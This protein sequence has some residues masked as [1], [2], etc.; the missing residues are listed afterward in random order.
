MVPVHPDDQPLLGIQWR[1]VTFVDRALPFGLRSAPKIFNSVADFPVWVLHC[2]GVSPLIHYLDDFLLFSPTQSM[3][4]AIARSR[5]ETVFSHIGAL[6]THHNTE[7]PA[8]V[9]TFLG[10]QIDTDLLQLSL[11]REKVT[12]LR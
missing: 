11:P 8:T 2:E 7:G 3:A 1:G 4:A 12:C 10:I 5:V 9:L 6:L